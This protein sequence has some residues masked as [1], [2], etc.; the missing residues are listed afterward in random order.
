MKN[1]QAATHLQSFECM[2]KDTDFPQDLGIKSIQNDAVI[3]L[4]TVQNQTN[5]NPSPIEEITGDILLSMDV[6]QMECLVDPII[7]K[8]G[9]VAL[10]GGSD[11]GKSSILRQLVI[12]C[13]TGNKQFLGFNLRTTHKSAIFVATEDD[14][15]ATAY[16]LKRQLASYSNKDGLKNLRFIFETFDLINEIDKRLTQ[17]PADIVIIDCFADAFGGDLKDSQ[18][19]RL[20]LHQYQE[21]AAQHQCLV[22]FLH[23]TAKRTES[24]EPSKH[25]LLSGQGFE[26]KM[27]LVMEL[28]ADL[29]NPNYRHLCIVKGNY[30]P[31]SF[32]KESFVLQFNEET[33]TFSN[34]GERTPFEFLVKQND[35]G[36]KSK[37]EQAQ[38]LKNL[39]Y[40][41]ELIAEKLGYSSKGSVSKLFKKAEQNGWSGSGFQRVSSGNDQETDE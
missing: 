1:Q 16:L 35:D 24:F 34:T 18:K 15:N 33:F 39:G 25:N 40:S 10:A 22:L 2:S 36:S 32:K 9:V 3:L 21:L 17:Q 27:R 12:D 20:F 29:M 19:I 4:K 7:P 38:E 6:K 13:V 37:Y 11:T 31:A 14:L 23:H 26:A 30:L 28:R 8:V 41:Y 5:N